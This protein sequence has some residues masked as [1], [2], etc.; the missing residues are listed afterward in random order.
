MSSV[1]SQACTCEHDLCWGA[2][3]L[4]IIH[5]FSSIL[6]PP[7]Y[8]HHPGT[9]AF[10]SLPCGSV[11]KEEPYQGS[12]WACAVRRQHCS[13]A[14]PPYCRWSGLHQV[15]AGELLVQCVYARARVCLCLSE[16]M[17]CLFVSLFVCVCV[18]VCVCVWQT[19][20]YCR[21][22][23]PFL[24]ATMS[25]LKCILYIYIYICMF[26]CMFVQPTASDS[27]ISLNPRNCRCLQKIFLRTWWKWLGVCST[28]CVGSFYVIICYSPSKRSCLRRLCEY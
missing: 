2:F 4:S 1:S 10:G 15:E 12:L 21:S 3:L 17:F 27:Y 20:R 13:S 16:S 8:C 23:S 28:L 25:T 7:R 19:P 5:S 18:C 6:F 11:W 22:F 26:V 24:Q 14:V 9:A